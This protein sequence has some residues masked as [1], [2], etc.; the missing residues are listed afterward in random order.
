MT[1]ARSHLVVACRAVGIAPPIDSVYPI[2]HDDE[3]LRAQAET[4]RRL[5]LF[6]KSAVH[7]TQL[8]TIH[9]VFEP[10]EAELQWAHQVVEEFESAGGAGVRLPTGE[11]VDLPVARA[12]FS[13]AARQ[14]PDRAHGGVGPPPTHNPA[15]TAVA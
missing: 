7:P 12:P 8:A 3:G 10:D 14:L 2:L 9:R 11:F 13:R 15:F 5:G 6:G 4:G 1:S